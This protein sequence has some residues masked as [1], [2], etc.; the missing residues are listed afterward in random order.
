MARK[1][2]V[3]KG[4]IVKKVNGIEVKKTKGGS[5]FIRSNA[6]DK[7]KRV[8]KNQG[9]SY[10]AKGGDVETLEKISKALAKGSKIHKKQ[11][12][13][14]EGASELHKTQSKQLDRIADDLEESKYAKG[15]K[16]ENWMNAT[17]GDSAL[18]ISENRMGLIVKAYGRKFHLEFPN[19]E[20]KTYDKNDLEFYGQSSSYDKGGKIDYE[21][22]EFTKEL[23]TED[24]IYYI[25]E[26]GEQVLMIR[27]SDNSVASD[28]YFAE[29]DLYERMVEIAN[30]REDYIYLRPES[31]PYLDEYKES[32]AKGGITE[33]KSHAEGG[34]PMEV[35]STGQ[36]VELEGGEGVINKKNMADT[37]KHEFEGKMLT[38]CEIA[39]EINSDGGNGVDIDC[40]GITGKKYKHEDGG[41]INKNTEYKGSVIGFKNRYKGNVESAIYLGEIDIPKNS[42]PSSITK[43]AESKYG[44]NNVWY[45]EV[46][47]KKGNYLYEVSDGKATA[48]EDGGKVG[49]RRSRYET[50]IAKENYYGTK[51]ESDYTDPSNWDKERYLGM[52]SIPTIDNR[53]GNSDYLTTSMK[54]DKFLNDAFAD[55]GA[56]E[57]EK[58][59]L[60][61]EISNHSL[62]EYDDYE[63]NNFSVA[64]L[65]YILDDLNEYSIDKQKSRF[66]ELQNRFERP[67]FDKGGN[68][69][70]D[71]PNYEFR[72]VDSG[73][74]THKELEEL[75]QDLYKPSPDAIYQDES[76]IDY[77]GMEMLEE[78]GM[79]KP[80]EVLRDY[81][82]KCSRKSSMKKM[83]MGGLTSTSLTD[84]EFN[85]DVEIDVYS[86]E[87]N[88]QYSWEAEDGVMYGFHFLYIDKSDNEVHFMMDGSSDVFS[89]KRNLI[90][91]EGYDFELGGE[92][93]KMPY[94]KYDNKLSE[95]D[96][97]ILDLLRRN[98]NIDNLDVDK[99]EFISNFKGDNLANKIDTNIIEKLYGLAYK[100][101]PSQITIED[102]LIINGGIG[103]IANQ[104]PEDVKVENHIYSHEF[105]QIEQK[106]SEVINKDAKNLSY[107]KNDGRKFDAIL[108]VKPYKN[109]NYF[110]SYQVYSNPMTI[111]VELNTFDDIDKMV[112]YKSSVNRDFVGKGFG[113]AIHNRVNQGLT[114]DT[115]YT[116]FTIFKIGY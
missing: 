15:G 109:P 98:P 23:E 13:Q 41:L 44:Y 5:F 18:V 48:Y 112:E 82:S 74:I 42:T 107:L 105:S 77:F 100:H 110:V 114:D 69:D 68:V 60:I 63:L 47:D 59:T 79:V 17:E 39:S 29:N 43:L 73:E 3:Q 35:S 51:P 53:V 25:D 113:S 85:R 54:D 50:D 45:V 33:G 57:N 6:K 9:T 37:K 7:W 55:G 106:I 116:L 88:F 64:K 97:D 58:E 8:T 52:T 20:D 84:V 70:M 46:A 101:K 56:V 90:D 92:V 28:N 96:K 40:D 93:G 11:S 62:N 21:G 61:L 95:Q 108:V 67:E 30:G 72:V 83:R 1:K 12:E 81:D 94:S 38:K 24:F 71:D 16:I 76:Q 22:E 66:N 4:T 27:K 49:G 78:G 80:T 75:K 65:K 19:G 2:A 10:F 87:G 36:K 91:I 31:V 86:Q 102:L 103:K 26:N 104:R 14:L 34:I 99:Q 111:M 32:F 115:D 89:V